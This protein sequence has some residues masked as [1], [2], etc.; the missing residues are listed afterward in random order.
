M[1]NKLQ[2]RE[3]VELTGLD[4]ETLR[5]YEQKGLLPKPDRTEAGYR[6]FDPDV[7]VRIQFIKLAQDVG[8][9]LKEI[10][11][12]LAFG[13]CSAVSKNELKKIAENKISSIDEKIKSLKTM[14]KVLVELSQRALS[15]S[16]KST[17][18]ILSQFKKLEL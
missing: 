17:C 13:E 11:E 15:L 3:I 1:K 9:T 8:F 16:K 4:R 2:I 6:Q 14:R 5:F 7:I 12:L 18:P 10:M